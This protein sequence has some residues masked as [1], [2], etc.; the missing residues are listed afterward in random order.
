[1]VDHVEAVAEVQRRIGYDFADIV[2][3]KRALTHA[4][5]GEGGSKRPH[6]QRLEFLGDRVLGLIVADNLMRADSTSR[7]G[8]MTAKFHAL[9]DKPACARAAQRAALG[10]ALRIGRGAGLMGLRNSVN[11]LGDA[12]E[13][14]LAAVYLDGGLEAARGVVERIWAEELEQPAGGYRQSAKTQ[15]SEW[16]GKA[17]VPHP[18]YRVVDRTGPDH[19]PE[20]TVMVELDHWGPMHGRGRSKLEAEQAAALAQLA[21]I[22]T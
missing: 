18:V 9:V 3:L 15:L 19:A 13:A 17:G 2:L 1:M 20:Y 8:E 11:V 7:E 16:A 22:L 6:N 12:C 4:S 14:V 10:P 5:A 21:R